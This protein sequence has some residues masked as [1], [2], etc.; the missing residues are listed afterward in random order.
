MKFSLV[1]IGIFIIQ[2]VSAQRFSIIE[3]DDSNAFLFDEN[4]SISLIS[5]AHK[6]YEKGFAKGQVISP[7]MLDYLKNKGLENEL[8]KKFGEIRF[9]AVSNIYGED[10][11]VYEDYFGGYTTLTQEVQSVEYFD[12]KNINQL[13]I[14]ENLVVDTIQRKSYYE[15]DRIGFAKRYPELGDKYFITFSIKYSDLIDGNGIEVSLPLIEE[16]NNQLVDERNPTSFLSKLRDLQFEKMKQD[17]ISNLQSSAFIDQ[18]RIEFDRFYPTE[19]NPWTPPKILSD[20]THFLVKTSFVSLKNEF[21]DDSVVV[22]LLTGEEFAVLTEI[23][24]SSAYWVDLPN[25]KLNICFRI[26]ANYY[27]DSSALNGEVKKLNKL[28]ITSKLTENFT[29]SYEVW[30]IDVPL[31]TESNFSL[32]ENLL[33]Y[34]TSADFEFVKYI[35]EFSKSKHKYYV[36]G[37]KTNTWIGKNY[38]VNTYFLLVDPNFG[39][40]FK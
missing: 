39:V 31:S 27:M 6:M 30:N 2:F 21:G 33:P 17:S 11:L 18:N 23:R 1:I 14:F 20:I 25:P 10:S 36:K 37:K 16:L 13:V 26:G 8:S 5:L 15:I 34:K 3:K 40:F 7:E 12:L 29:Y 19:I 22:D 24:D 32:V 38:F 35:N 4:N 28:L 9:E